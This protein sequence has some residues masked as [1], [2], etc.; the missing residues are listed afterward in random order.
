ML[1]YLLTLAFLAL[2]SGSIIL[3]FKTRFVQIRTL[4]LMI[5]LLFQ[6]FLK[7]NDTTE[8]TIKAHR[9]LFTAMATAF[10]I[11]NIVAPI[12]A[13]GFGGPGALIGFALAS[14]FGAA[15]AFTEVSLALSYRKKLSDGTIMGGPM[16]Y[17]KVGLS[18]AFAS[19]YA[20]AGC[21]MLVAWSGKQTN[22]LA[23]LLKSYSIPE[24]LTGM[25]VVVLTAFIL[26]RGIKLIGSIAEK[27][28][29]LMFFVY[30]SSMLYILIRHI[31]N[32]PGAIKI[33]FQ[34]AFTPQAL[35]GAGVGLGLQ[36]AMQWGLSEATFANEA[37]VGTITIPH[38]MAATKSSVNQ[39]ILSMISVY[40][41]GFLALLSGLTIISSGI[42]LT[43]EADFD[44][45]MLSDL[46][47]N[48]FSFIGPIILLATVILFAFT[49]ILGNSY[50]GSQCFLYATKNRWLTRYYG[51][52]AII[53]F[54]CAI[55]DVK[56]IWSLGAYFIV[57][58]AIP[59]V[60]GI[61]ILSFRAGLQGRHR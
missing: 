5:K 25:I 27:L 35:A 19:L 4:P 10:G 48:H 54:T 58:V 38:S 49:S 16:Q 46:L 26:M 22:T 23:V 7:K 59:N 61:V 11:G 42:W 21:I 41:S 3:S 36:K 9:A 55:L 39:G 20:I 31:H 2:L 24:Y 37:G 34:S 52:I 40:T 53:I 18:P 60:V 29:P 30:S 43:P 45:T 51:L 44:I 33:V 47:Y 8:H 17:L 14:F 57:P 56:T 13:I 15:T 1:H 50:N 6:S 12:V 32:L 28:I